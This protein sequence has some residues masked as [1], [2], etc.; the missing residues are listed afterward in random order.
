M[1]PK[2]ELLTVLLEWKPNEIYTMASVQRIKR[3]AADFAKGAVHRF[4]WGES[5]KSL[6]V[7]FRYAEE[8][9]VVL[10]CHDNALQLSCTCEAAED[11][12]CLHQLIALM[13]IARVLKDSRFHSDDLPKSK[14]ETFRKQLRAPKDDDSEQTLIFRVRPGERLEVD[15]D[16]GRRQASW[17]VTKPPD[18]L[19]WLRLQRASPELVPAAFVQ[20]LPNKPPRMQIAIHTPDGVT[21]LSSANVLET[22]VDLALSRDHDEIV[23]RRTMWTAEKEQ[24]T[25]CIDLGAGLVYVPKLR[26]FG[27]A[28]QQEGWSGLDAFLSKARKVSAS[29]FRMEPADFNCTATLPPPKGSVRLLGNPGGDSTVA[30]TAVRA[31]LSFESDSER[32]VVRP[33]ILT[34][35]GTRLDNILWSRIAE[36]FADHRFDALVKSPGNRRALNQWL[37]LA[38]A[39][40]DPAELEEISQQ[41]AHDPA[42]VNPAIFGNDAAK[43]IQRVLLA[44]QVPEDFLVSEATPEPWA[45]V[46]GFREWARRLVALW[47]EAVSTLNLAR[48]FGSDSRLTAA[49]LKSELHAIVCRAE[50]SGIPV[51]FDEQ[52][53]RPTS[54]QVSVRVE[55]AGEIDWFELHPSATA[56]AWTI[57]QEQWRKMIECGRADGP[58]GTIWVAEPDAVNRL[59]R[60][61][62]I[63]GETQ[64]KGDSRR[65]ARLRLFDWLALRREGVSCELPAEDATTLETVAGLQQIPSIPVPADLRAELREY[66][67]HGFEWLAFLYEHRFG[68]CLADDMGLGKT[69]QA[70]ALLMHASGSRSR[71][72]VGPHLVVVPPT[73]LFNWQSELSRFSPELKCVEHSLKGTTDFDGADVVL[74]TYDRVRRNIET[75]SLREFEIAV[76]DE[77]QAIKNGAAARTTAVR[78]I[79]ARFRV[80]LT[81]TPLENHIGEFHSIMEA[82]VPGLFGE[83]KLFLRQHEAGIGVLNRAAPFLLRRTKQTI[84]K[85][86]PPRV[87][88][89]MYFDLNDTQK[90]CYTRAVA[91]VRSEVMAA[92]E[93]RPAQQAGMIA[94]AALL[95]LRQIC[96]SP[97]MLPGSEPSESPKLEYLTEQL[98]ELCAEGH[99]ALVFSQFVR[100]LDLT[101][102]ALQ[103]AEIPFL[104]MDGRTPLSKR[105]ADIESF[106]SG[107]G[108]GVFLI[109]LKTGGAGLNLTRASYVY[110]LDPWWNPAVE[111]QASDRAHRI[112][113][114]QSVFIHRLLMRHTIEEK[115]MDLKMRKQALFDSVV[116]GRTATDLAGASGLSAEDFRYLLGTA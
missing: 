45:I 2:P 84:L 78:E 4:D 38:L 21:S 24:V 114:K 7:S 58:D 77:A 109:S 75:L 113:Q 100:A 91:E 34:Q 41:A 32:T 15:Y 72:R 28:S 106:Q 96:I 79:R 23:L 20:W 19:E 52:T 60:V 39:T 90:E 22:R 102:E 95:R 54:V 31:V 10:T 29:E 3:A 1:K 93:D 51:V 64:G 115:M 89:D 69:L 50:E 105:K 116:E 46:G 80:C 49:E 25:D 74:T 86:L 63:W 82:A 61:E 12:V 85:E 59:G 97:E 6:Q 88:S 111:R 16:S 98:T 76:F 18:G 47:I 48:P 108:P 104:R 92:Y 107:E 62:A 27:L 56:G 8:M 30:A 67:R 26:A 87:E 65:V 103:A 83:R 5:G 53:V 44:L 110:H 55:A 68:A 37:K 36:A 94:L 99:A 66:Q 81:G 71:E 70:I 40:S 13:T 57:P 9:H 35:R 42:F 73:L 11:R 14:I 33:R 43:C 17:D 112:G 101:A